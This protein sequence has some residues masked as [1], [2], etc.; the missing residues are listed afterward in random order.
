MRLTSVIAAALAATFFISSPASS[1]DREVIPANKTSGVTFIYSST[2]LG[3]NCSNSGRGKYKV[4]REAKHGSVRLEWRKVK[5]DFHM[6]CK[7]RSMS[8]VAVFY[9]PHKGFRGDDDF[10][11]LTTSPG[12]QGPGSSRSRTWKLKVTVK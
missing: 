2:G 12:F 9:T 5:G 11:V 1:S 10:V 7:N 8:G 3:H 4:T 6:G